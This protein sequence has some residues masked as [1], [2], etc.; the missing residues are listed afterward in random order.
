MK[1]LF[2]EYF[3]SSEFEKSYKKINNPIKLNNLILI[4]KDFINYF[5]K[6][7]LK[8]ETKTNTNH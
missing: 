1:E 8:Q 4:G 2:N 3:I 6:S 5:S 7:K